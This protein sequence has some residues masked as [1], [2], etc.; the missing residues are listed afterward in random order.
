MNTIYCHK[1]RGNSIHCSC[2]NMAVV[3]DSIVSD[4]SIAFVLFKLK[5]RHIILSQ[6]QRDAIFTILNPRDVVICLPIG[7]SVRRVAVASAPAH[8]CC[9]WSAVMS[10]VYY[11]TPSN[12]AISE[13]NRYVC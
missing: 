3:S 6:H 1:N 8:Q 13:T 2:Q 9:F 11:F 5:L 4:E 10:S 12:L 7:R